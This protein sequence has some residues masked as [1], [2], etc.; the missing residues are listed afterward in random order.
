MNTNT[1]VMI[2]KMAKCGL[3][4]NS[5]LIEFTM[6]RNI[7]N[8]DIEK[9]VKQECDFD[10]QQIQ[11]FKIKIFDSWNHIQKVFK[12]NEIAILSTLLNNSGVMTRKQLVRK[13]GISSSRIGVSIDNLVGTPFDNAIDGL[14][15]EGL[16]DTMQINNNEIL[17]FINKF[18]FETYFNKK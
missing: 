13:T 2:S 15:E 17:V 6:K 11:E 8:S 12:P 4:D 18:K 1:R 7:N 14:I 5:S 16:I 10:Y 3:I 9:F